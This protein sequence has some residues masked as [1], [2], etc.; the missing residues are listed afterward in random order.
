MGAIVETTVL[1]HLFDYY[2]RDTP[3]IGYWRDA[4]QR[5]RE[6]DIVVKSPKY[7]LPFE[8]K[9]HDRA[10]LEANSGL[11]SFCATERPSQ[12]YLVTKTD[13]DFGVSTLNG[14]PVLKIPA[15]ILTYLLGQAERH[16]WSSTNRD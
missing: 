6:V 16:L 12:A 10:E 9:Y 1:R 11:A 13:T 3:Q 7:S 2:Y 4:R 15:H 8:V 14:V 5:D